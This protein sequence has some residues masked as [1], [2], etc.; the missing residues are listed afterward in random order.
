MSEEV[1][2]KLDGAIARHSQ[3]AENL[4]V[5]LVRVKSVNPEFPGIT[6]GEYDGGEARVNAILKDRFEDAG[7]E[8][9][10]VEAVSGRP[11]LVGVRPGSGE[12]RSLAVNG[13]V[14]TVAPLRLSEW[15]MAD[16]WEPEIRERI[17]WGL[18]TTDMKA[19][20]AA[21]WLAAKAMSEAELSLAGDFQLHSVVGEETM[22]HHLGTTAVLDAG[23]TTDGAI[24]AEGTSSP[25]LDLNI[26]NTAAGNYLFHIHIKGKATHWS[27]RNQAIRA[28]G[29]GDAIGVNAIDKAVYVYS[30]MR[31]LEDQWAFTKRHEQFSPGFFIINPGVLRAD[32]GIEAPPYL[33]DRA[34]IDYLLSFPPGADSNEI[35]SEVENHIFAACQLDPWLKE[36][37][38]VFEWE[39]TWPPAFTD[40]RSP[41]VSEVI[42]ARGLLGSESAS[43]RVEAAHAI[44]AQTDASFYEA[45]G[46]PAIVCGPGDMRFA[47]SANE[48]VNLD[49]VSE[50]AKLYARTALAWCND[51]DP[52]S[53]P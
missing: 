23:F 20:L 3:D 2:A 38:V 39:N 47:H 16:P 25:P 46:V 52:A 19:G 28:G 33:P 27:L 9:H 31:Q 8:T 14:D 45:K 26:C 13:H 29:A 6:V 41:F 49:L 5:E 32:I 44:G 48:Q 18:G 12:G 22:S 53:H 11:N 37:P 21:M 43:G 17:L 34:R 35:M 40:P 42:A 7:L 50:A 4:L 10:T 24:V 15:D 30:A 51:A 36:H 1:L